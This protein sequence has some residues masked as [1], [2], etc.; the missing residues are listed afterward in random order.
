MQ[1]SE[2]IISDIS[3]R[4]GYLPSLFVPAQP[5]PQ[6]L[7]NLWEQTLAAYVNN[8][9]PDLFKEKLFAYL[10]RYCCVPYC[11]ICHSCTLG[12][13]G[14]SA[15]QILQLLSSPTPTTAESD[16]KAIAASSPLTA[17]PEPDSPLEK[18]IFSCCVYIF[19]NPQDTICRER[20]QQLGSSTYDRLMAILD[21]IKTC[22]L[23]V[24]AH[25]ALAYQIDPPA[26]ATLESLFTA[27]Q[28]LVE[29]FR[30]YNALLKQELAVNVKDRVAA[31][32]KLKQD[33][34]FEQLTDNIR[35][36]FWIASHEKNELYY[37]SPAYEE[38]WQRKRQQLYENP[39]SFLDFIHPEDRDRVIA[40]RQK[41]FQTEVEIEYRI[42][43]LDGQERWIRD[44]A[45]PII[46]EQG[47]IE[48]LVGIADDI[49]QSKQLQQELWESEQRLKFA[50][51]VARMGRWEWNILTDKITWS[52]N[53]E[54]LFN[55]EKGTFDGTHKAL[56][57]SI[58]P[59]DREF[60]S[61]SLKQAVWEGKEYDIE[62]R[63]IGVDGTIGFC[64]SKGY[65]FRDP[66]GN[67]LRM[68]GV[69][70][71]IT[72]SKLIEQQLRLSESV[73]VNAKDAILITEAEPIDQP[74]P[75]ILYVNPAF[76]R[77]TGYSCDQILG[78][79]PRFLQ[80]AKSDRATLDKIRAAI[81][82]WES[83]C[84]EIINYR[85]DGSEFW[86]EISLVPVADETGWYTHWIAIQRD[87]SDRKQ[88][89]A[90]YQM[91]LAAEQAARKAAEAANRTKDEFLAIV[92]HELRSPLNAMLGWA[93][94]LRTRK[95][96][97]DKTAHG[98]EII[99]RNARLQAQL[100]E[101]LLDLSR[102]IRGK[103]QLN[104]SQVNL[105]SAIEAAIDVVYS[106]A[107]SKNIQLNFTIEQETSQNSK[108]IN[109]HSPPDPTDAST[110]Q[111]FGDSVRLQQIIWN[112]LSNAVKFTP[113]GGQVEIKLSVE[114]QRQ[115]KGD[116]LDF[117]SVSE[118][119]LLA[120]NSD[121]C[122]L[123]RACPLPLACIQVIDTGIG[124]SPDFLPYVFER[125][126]QADSSITRSRSGLGLG[127]TIVR[128]LVELHHGSVSV[129]SPGVGLGSTFTVKIPLLTTERN[130]GGEDSPFQNLKSMA[131][132]SSSPPLTG[133]QILVVDDEA[134]ARELISTVL[135]HYGARVTAV[136][137][138]AL[139]LAAVEK[140]QPAVLV[141][142][143][144]MPEENGYSLIRKLRNIEAEQGGKI[145]AIA[146]SAYARSEDRAAAIA[147]G[148]QA[149]LPKP[150][151]PTQ[152]AAVVVNVIQQQ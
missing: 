83:I 6:L 96:D 108:V 126:R 80:G 119:L 40:A 23:W 148:F 81:Q 142:D 63:V 13:L 125:F 62:F 136:A 94:L 134:D 74:G 86:A 118:S 146:L 149:H 147:A 7:E 143:L 67:P 70:M 27:E 139:A 151:E 49:T 76:S 20:L 69:D 137:S 104:T 113:E 132:K 57:Q 53:L 112:L 75:R 25:P 124:I 31:S 54:S 11:I 52:E 89:Q 64:A 32:E 85:K 99:E 18:A 28:K 15:K 122:L 37:V 111:V 114:D 26:L 43:R 65:V 17:F 61:H 101:D 91:L 82:N 59:Q 84:V 55:Q 30:N 24:E 144:G 16:I 107:Q 116:V 44:R 39:D 93:R 152:L 123:P 2:Q 102:M 12:Q 38:I 8:P 145:P 29:F 9:L 36:V 130:A 73:V 56:I 135:E 21:Y 68:V 1:T 140:L 14:M 109:H 129:E 22:H 19:L 5:E 141:S 34:L 98:L 41:Q 121:S 87:I 128:S 100:I 138:A 110:F 79:S 3:A 50:L 58:H 92:S 77:M 103:L 120:D 4:F 131:P 33:Q 35:Q 48:R 47:Q 115:A 90:E 45:F 117:T 10:S 71:D 88:Q 133:L 127:L 46:N 95:F 97:S 66:A 105:I 150:F 60:V 42:I 72:K 78:R 106:T 51:E